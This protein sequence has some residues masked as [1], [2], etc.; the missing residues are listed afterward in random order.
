MKSKEE[1]NDLAEI[2]ANQ[3]MEVYKSMDLPKGTKQAIF[4]HCLVSYNIGYTQC[5]EDMA[6]KIKE[7]V[8]LLDKIVENTELFFGWDVANKNANIRNAKIFI[9]SLNKQD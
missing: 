3:E 6:D 9:K 8:N 1:I 7:A 4:T 5:Q 2:H